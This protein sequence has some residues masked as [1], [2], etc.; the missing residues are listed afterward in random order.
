MIAYQPHVVSSIK[1]SF[2][3]A[4]TLIA[5]LGIAPM[6]SAQWYVGPGITHLALKT[7]KSEISLGALTGNPTAVNEADVESGSSVPSLAIGYAFGENGEWVLESTV[8]IGFD[9][10]IELDGGAFATATIMPVNVFGA[11]QGKKYR[12]ENS[13]V[14]VRPV[15]GAGLVYV[16]HTDTDLVSPAISALGNPRLNMS[17]STSLALLAGVNLEFPQSLSVVLAYSYIDNI[18]T[19]V[20]LEGLQV[21]VPFVGFS[22]AFNAEIGS[23]DLSSS[24]VSARVQFTF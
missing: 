7:S 15:V 6:A 5:L 19:D 23:V 18:E 8:S 20:T 9:E 17:D 24:I 1:R 21:P 11:F 10:T 16:T 4:V 2:C 13:D 22:Q 14:S 3:S 12:F